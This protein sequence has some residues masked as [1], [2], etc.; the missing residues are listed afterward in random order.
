MLVAN[1]ERTWELL[2]RCGERVIRRLGNTSVSHPH[3]QRLPKDPSV[4]GKKW[5]CCCVFLTR[6]RPQRGSVRPQKASSQPPESE[7]VKNIPKPP[8]ADANN[9]NDANKCRVPNVRRRRSEI[10][11]RSVCVER[12]LIVLIFPR[13]KSNRFRHWML[14]MLRAKWLSSVE[15]SALWDRPDL[16]EEG[17][18]AKFAQFQ[19]ASV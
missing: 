7:R 19:L 4:E 8:P 11:S 13:R 18:R 14:E 1:M 2:R 12:R 3:T 17:T 10:I 16:R 9:R 6:E 5:I 15:V